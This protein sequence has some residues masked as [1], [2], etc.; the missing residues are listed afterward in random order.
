MLAAPLYALLVLE[1]LGLSFLYGHHAVA[2]GSALG[3]VI[4]WTGVGSMLL[5]HVYSLRKRIGAMRGMGKLRTWLQ[6]H[7]FLGLQGAL[8]V[9]FH[10]LHMRTIGNLAG[11]TL[12]L[13][14]IVVCSGIFGRY[15]FSLIPKSLTGERLTAPQIESELSEVR[16]RVEAAKVPAIAAALAEIDAA[17]PLDQRAGIFVLIKEDLR[18]RTALSHLQQALRDATQTLP[19]A[20]LD[21]LRA[22]VL[23]RGLLARR[24]AMLAGADRLFRNWTVLHKPLTYLLAGSAILHVIAH[25]IYAAQYGA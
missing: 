2:A 21:E 9:V 17:V 8:L 12:T 13:T 18:A 20:E 25:Y 23:R 14:G 3:M 7:I 6:L 5:M 16:A 15:L 19:A 4:G 1:V 22:V 10:S 24:L 11:I